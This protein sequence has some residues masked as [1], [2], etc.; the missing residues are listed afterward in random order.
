MRKLLACGCM[1]V[2]LLQGVSAFA[3][4]CVDV[5]LRA[6]K[7]SGDPLDHLALYYMLANCGDLG[8][9]DIE[10]SL[11]KDGTL[12]RKVDVQRVLPAARGFSHEFLLPILPGVAAGSYR[13]CLAASLGS[14][15]DSACATVVIDSGG[16]VV[17]FTPDPSTAVQEKPWGQMKGRYR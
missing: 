8:N 16:Y 12:V 3:A 5:D 10:L 14:A 17:S 1:V 4:D 13:L 15:S 7:I 11:E 9:A 6:Q 2:G